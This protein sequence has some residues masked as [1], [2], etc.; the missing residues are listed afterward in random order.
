MIEARRASEEAVIALQL[1]GAISLNKNKFSNCYPDE[2]CGVGKCGN[3]ALFNNLG[4]TKH[5][6]MISSSPFWQ[7]KILLYSIRQTVVLMLLK[8]M[9]V[10]L[11]FTYAP[12]IRWPCHWAVTM[13]MRTVGKLCAIKRH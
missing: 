10:D 6:K 4:P 12:I 9:K 13:T 2:I 5:D 1:T 3:L 11:F 7:I 8:M